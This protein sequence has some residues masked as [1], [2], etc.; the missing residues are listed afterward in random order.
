MFQEIERFINIVGIPSLLLGFLYIGKRLQ[1]L[2]DINNTVK[3]LKHNI[4]VIC[5]HLISKFD[6]FDHTLLVNYSP[7]KLKPEAVKLLEIIGFIEMFKQHKQDFFDLINNEQPKTKF[8]VELQSIKAVLILFEKDYFT[9]VKNY[10]YNNPNVEY[11]KFAQVLGI[12]V[13]DKYFNEHKM[14]L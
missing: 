6:G 8:D 9:E 4:K 11:K 3:S 1:L 7:L 10:L 5:D 14:I 2:D 13:R 12:Y